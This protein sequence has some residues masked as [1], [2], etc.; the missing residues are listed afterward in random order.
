MVWKKKFGTRFAAS[1]RF[2]SYWPV[3]RRPSEY[4]NVDFDA[5]M[6]MWM[7]ILTRERKSCCFAVGINRSYFL[8][9]L[10]R[11]LHGPIGRN[12]YPWRRVDSPRLSTSTYPRKFFDYPFKT[13]YVCLF[14]FHHSTI[15]H[16]S[17][18]TQIWSVDTFTFFVLTVCVDGQIWI[19]RSLAITIRI[20]NG[21]NGR[22]RVNPF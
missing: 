20:C 3:K 10:Q 11:N 7:R 18:P 9:F 22:L 8:S 4:Q 17:P 21:H 12:L 15:Y 19:I 5:P 14:H 16:V 13:A 6:K 2:L 1:T